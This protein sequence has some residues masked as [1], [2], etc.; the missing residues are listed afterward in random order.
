MDAV[1]IHIPFCKKICSYCDFCKIYLNDKFTLPYLNALLNEIKDRYQG[2]KI[3]T[4]YIGGG[5]P[6]CLSLKDLNYLFDIIKLFD[7]SELKEFTFECN[8]NDI[9]EEILKVLQSNGVNRLSI[10]I[11]SFN[12]N[13]LKFMN[14]FHTFD[15]VLD[16]INLCRSYNFNNINLDLIYGL[17]NESISILKKDLKLL[18]KLNPE[19]ISTYSLIIEDNTM[20]GIN[21]MVPVDEETDSEMYRIICQIL[22]KNNYIHYE[23]SNFA[24]EGYASLHNINYWLNE[25]YYGFGLSSHGY[26]GNVRYENTRSLTNYINGNYVLSEKLLS[27][28]DDMDNTIMLGFRLLQGINLKY[29]YDKY[30]VNLQEKYDIKELVDKK[31]LLYKDGYLKINPKYIYMMNEILIKII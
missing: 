9:N 5:T 16:K 2:E 6:S 31:Y 30:S 14:R 26:I 22:K 10:G 21:Q 20:I 7:L 15:D 18:L 13:N 3:K 1:Y 12:E 23:V 11:E 19:H 28:S 27:S 25:N 29:F 17:P 4:L 24:K 8:I